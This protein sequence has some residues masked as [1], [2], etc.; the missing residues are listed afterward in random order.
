MVLLWLL[1]LPAVPESNHLAYAGSRARVD[2]A[3]RRNPVG[4]RPV[5]L[6]ESVVPHPDRRSDAR[7]CFYG[8]RLRH[9]SDDAQRD[10][11][12]RSRHRN[13]HDADPHLGF[14]SGRHVVRD[15]DYERG[16]T[17]DQQIRKT[18][19][20]RSRFRQN[21]LKPYGKFSEKYGLFTFST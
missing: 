10:V 15:P 14:L 21:P 5:A 7:S 19:T 3:V 20:L 2:G 12:V 4:G 13:H 11:A 8:H 6:H 16:R 1:L 17:A 18:E 9:L